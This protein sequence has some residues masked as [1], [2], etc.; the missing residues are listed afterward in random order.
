MQP[1]SET[2]LRIGYS[3][4]GDVFQSL[5]DAILVNVQVTK[6]LEHESLNSMITI[7]HQSKACSTL[8]S[9]HS[10]IAAAFIIKRIR[11]ANRETQ[12]SVNAL[13]LYIIIW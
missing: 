5:S 13:K 1:L 3:S 4:L 2:K 9:T 10:G 8:H 7:V 6:N 11:E 12:R